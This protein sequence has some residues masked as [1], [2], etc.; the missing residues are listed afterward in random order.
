DRPPPPAS[1][2]RAPG[3]RSCRASDLLQYRAQVREECARVLAHRKMTEA[4]HDG[5]LGAWNS[6]GGRLRVAWRGG[7]VVFAGQQVQR[8]KARIDSADAAADVALHL[9]EV[10]VARENARSSLHV[11][12]DR[13]P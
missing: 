11:V 12:P 8:A 6:L 13:L 1:A 7:V 2:R 4:F 9:V 10:Q 3:A 5:H